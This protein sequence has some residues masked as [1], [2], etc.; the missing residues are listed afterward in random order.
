MKKTV[1]YKTG[2][3]FTVDEEMALLKLHRESDSFWAKMCGTGVKA[4]DVPMVDRSHYVCGDAQ[5]APPNPLI[6][7]NG[8]AKIYTRL[9]CPRCGKLFTKYYQSQIYCRECEPVK[10]RSPH[11]KPVLQFTK[12]GIFIKEYPSV[13]SAAE[14]IGKYRVAIA[15]CCIG[16]A[17][18]AHGYIWKYKE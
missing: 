1:K 17:Q 14:A 6:R 3:A 4:E 13:N 7:L 2:W 8:E 5:G 11:A 15:N 16:K 9:N 12:N 18:T 10:C